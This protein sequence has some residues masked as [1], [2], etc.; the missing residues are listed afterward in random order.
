[1]EFAKY[2]NVSDIVDDMIKNEEIDCYPTG[3]DKFEGVYVCMDT[4]DFW[5]S[6]I[7]KGYNEE[8]E[9]DENKYLVERNKISI[10]DVMDKLH[11]M[12][13]KKLPEFKEDEIFYIQKNKVHDY[14][15]KFSTLNI[16]KAVI[17]LDDYDGLSNWDCCEADSLEEAIEIIDG[18]YGILKIAVW[19]DIMVNIQWKENGNIRYENLLSE[20]SVDDFVTGLK[21]RECTEIEIIKDIERFVAEKN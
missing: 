12:Y 2:Y 21:D 11:E 4:N 7:N 6:R 13:G 10:Y 9:E 5:I 1:M 18:G 3:E 14:L 8:Y 17:I 16:I 19:G 15:R 20:K